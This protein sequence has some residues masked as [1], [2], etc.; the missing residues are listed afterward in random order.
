MDE[1]HKIEGLEFGS[2]QHREVVNKMN[3]IV[4]HT[5]ILSDIVGGLNNVV[6]EIVDKKVNK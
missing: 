4:E 3:E 2:S 6:K 1:L 5:N